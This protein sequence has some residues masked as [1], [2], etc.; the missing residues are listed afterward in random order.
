MGIGTFI[1]VPRGFFNTYRALPLESMTYSENLD[2]LTPYL[3]TLVDLQGDV[4]EYFGWTESDDIE[5]ARA[6]LL[7]VESSSVGKWARHNR[8]VSL[9]RLFRRLVIRKARVAILGA[10]IEP[11]EILDILS[12]P[13]LIVAADGAAGVIS[14]IPGSLSEKAWSR[15]ACMVSDADGGEGTIQA[16]RRAIPIFLHAHG[17]NRQD[18]ESLLGV[19]EDQ[20]NPPE[21]VLTHQTS[22][23]I[24]GMHNPGGFTDGDRAACILTA[25]GVSKNQIKM[26][27]TRTD[28]VGRWS[29]KTQEQTKI[30]KLQWMSRILSIQGLSM[31]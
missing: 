21:L 8:A 4:R 24:V 31:D 3:S 16:V 1:R 10:A 26:L 2:D 5:S 12:E 28:V 29:G 19:A 20:V 17:D 6:M 11:E 18:W 9:S 23:R 13:I 22:E 14:E 7:R 30:E 25:L 15:V 27:G